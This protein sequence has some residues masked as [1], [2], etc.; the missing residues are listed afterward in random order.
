MAPDY[1]DPSEQGDPIDESTARV[2]HRRADARLRRAET[3]A[4]RTSSAIGA[5]LE[6]VSNVHT[7]HQENDF[8]RRIR[9]SYRGAHNHA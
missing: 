9:E 2:E 5:F 3:G 4:Q 1:R 8:T 7:M 6:V